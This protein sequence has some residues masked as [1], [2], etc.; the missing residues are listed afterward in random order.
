MTSGCVLEREA[1]SHHVEGEVLAPFSHLP[2]PPPLA[3][4]TLQDVEMEGD[5][6]VWEGG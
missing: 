6:C 4:V 3:S 1:P 2:P 5:V